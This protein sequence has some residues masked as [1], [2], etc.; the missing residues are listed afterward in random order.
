MQ[1]ASQ[2]LEQSRKTRIQIMTEALKTKCIET[3]KEKHWFTCAKNI[4]RNKRI[5]QFFF[6]CAIRN[7][8]IQGT[9]KNKNILIAGPTNCGKSF[10]LEPLELIF[11][12]FVDPATSKYAST[13]LETKEVT[14]LND[15]RWSLECNAWSDLLLLEGQTFNLLCPKIQFA[16]DLL[17]DRSDTLS[18]FETIK[19]SVKYVGKFNLQDEKETDL[20]ASRWQMF[21]FN[22]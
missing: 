11:N 13:K 1:G 10:L 9:Q 6:A 20:M 21:S 18:I 3:C 5:N 15:L 17:I 19:S 14:F 12:A 8:L 2:F 22:H 16:A 7:T 4:F